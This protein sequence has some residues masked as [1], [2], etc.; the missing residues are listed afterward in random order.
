M[1]LIFLIFI[2]KTLLLADKVLLPEATVAVVN[3]IAISEDDLQRQISKLIPR[4]YFHSNL[5]EKKLKEVT[6]KSIDSLIEQTLFYTYAKKKNITA[7]KNEIDETIQKYIKELGSKKELKKRLIASNTSFTDFRKQIERNIVYTKLYKKEIELV[8]SDDYLKQYYEKNKFKFKEPEKIKVSLIYVRNDPT[9][10]NGK[11]K[12]KAKIIEA[13]KK[14]KDGENFPYIAQTYSDDPTRVKGGDIGYIH[15]GRLDETIEE[16]AFSL[17]ANSTSNI[18]QKDIGY[19]IVRVDAKKEQN[20]IS[21]KDAK[22]TI[23]TN[24]KTKKEDERK[25]KL[26]K[27]LFSTA[28]IIK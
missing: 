1:K 15:K 19:F 9:D 23:V 18:I 7:T 11:S 14:L 13:Q 10:P 3:S 6:K 2:V 22:K 16:V 26:L 12:A 21:F 8:I 24:L 25:S 5:N 17:D 28:V 20:Q 27:R 4:S